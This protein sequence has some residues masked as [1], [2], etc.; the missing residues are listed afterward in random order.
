MVVE[1]P[2]EKEKKEKEGLP[3]VVG[4]SILKIKQY[5]LLTDPSS[6]LMSLVSLT[7]EIV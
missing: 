2:D 3:P 4:W 5:R 1:I 6:Q 7:Q